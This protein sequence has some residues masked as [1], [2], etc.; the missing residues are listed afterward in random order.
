[1]ESIV[2]MVGKSREL[3][4][5]IGTDYKRIIREYE[6]NRFDPRMTT[7]LRTN[8]LDPIGSVQ[9]NEFAQTEAELN[10]FHASMKDGVAGVATQQAP[11]TLAAMQ[12]LLDQL[13]AI[14]KNMGDTFGLNEMRVRLLQIIKKQ[15]EI[16]QKDIEIILKDHYDKLLSI[17]VTAPNS[18][19]VAPGKSEKVTVKVRMP[20]TLLR[21]PFLRFEIPVNSGLKITPSEVPLKDDS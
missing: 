2:E 17:V 6:V 14:R 1:V 16:G 12:K 8:I 5:E 21:D 9:T 4:A 13:V 19:N 7:G 18:V 3:T 10:K 15:E 11:P 20:E